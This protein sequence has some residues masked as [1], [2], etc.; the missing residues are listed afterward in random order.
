L[1]AGLGAPSVREKLIWF[2]R[3]GGRARLRAVNLSVE[4]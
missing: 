4:R 3:V 1:S 2:L